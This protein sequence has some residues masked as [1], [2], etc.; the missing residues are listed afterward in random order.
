MKILITGSAG[1][2]GFHTAK[3]LLEQNHQ[4]VG[5][6]NFN[7]YYDPNLKKERNKILEEFKNFK[8]YKIDFS[9]YKKTEEIFK[10]EKIDKICHLGA[11]AGVRYSIENPQVYI[12]SN[13]QGTFNIFELARQYKIKDIV[14]AS[15]SSIYGNNKKV[16]FSEIDKVDNPI[17]LYAATKK[18]SELIAHTY[19]HLY[20][21]NCTGLRFF[22]VY[23]PWGRPDMAYFLFSK[24]IDQNKAIKV[25]NHGKLERDFTYID[26]IVEGIVKALK[27]PFGY[28]IINLGNNKPVKLGYFIE[29]I[30]KELGKK[31]KKEMMPMQPGDVK[32]TYANISK[33][34]KLL[35][36]E[37]KTNIE[38]GLKQFINWYKLK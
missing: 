31:A 7:D 18:S 20:G 8:L 3:K 14:F 5:I 37:P 23:G 11:Q 6:D 28:E 30:E 25:F 29:C 17:S 33:A 19:H 24:A 1:F 13:I 21:L 22:T 38:Q 15:S 2:I 16:P 27:N 9:D 36:W 32:R 35:N 10:K 34:K 12:D 26:D 4:V